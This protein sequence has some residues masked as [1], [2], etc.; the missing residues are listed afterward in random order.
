M[1]FCVKLNLFQ[2]L[3]NQIPNHVQDDEYDILFCADYKNVF[4]TFYA[5]L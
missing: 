2:H 4:L 3:I 1:V 5:Y